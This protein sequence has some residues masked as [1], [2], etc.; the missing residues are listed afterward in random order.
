[1]TLLHLDYIDG[2][3][4]EID[5]KANAGREP[6]SIFVILGRDPRIHASTLAEGCNG[7]EFWSAAT[8][9]RHGMD[10]RVSATEL[11]SCFALE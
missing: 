6:Q 9:A 11:R 10:S 5:G 4:P 2:G 7:A 8:L 1:M 3:V